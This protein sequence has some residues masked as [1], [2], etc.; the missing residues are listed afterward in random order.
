MFIVIAC[1]KPEALCKWDR[2]S[3]SFN[4]EGDNCMRLLLGAGVGVLAGAERAKAPGRQ[5]NGT[6]GSHQAT[7]QQWNF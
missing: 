3:Y 1:V 5:V 2:T 7:L 4:L 6:L